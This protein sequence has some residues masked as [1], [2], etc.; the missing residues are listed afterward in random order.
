M[1]ASEVQPNQ[2]DEGHKKHRQSLIHPVPSTVASRLGGPRHA[3]LSGRGVRQAGKLLIRV[4][5]RTEAPDDQ[6]GCANNEKERGE[7][8]KR[9]MP[10]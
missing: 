7:M 4:W 1:S 9:V 2:G 8:E 3:Y 5:R 10:S 6:H